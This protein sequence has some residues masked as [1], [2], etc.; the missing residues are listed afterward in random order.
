MDLRELLKSGSVVEIHSL[1]E[2]FM[3]GVK[4]DCSKIK[5]GFKS[6]I[7]INI[8]NEDLILDEHNSIEKIY[9]HEDGELR[10]LW[11]RL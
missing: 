8:F 6:D 1:D 4:N 5:W 10:L 2:V 11:Y 9:I 7:D 3:G